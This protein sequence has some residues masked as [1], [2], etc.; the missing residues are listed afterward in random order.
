MQSAACRKG[1]IEQV[2]INSKCGHSIPVKLDLCVQIT[3]T[4][5]FAP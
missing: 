5:I 1:K 3:E 4:S 2:Y